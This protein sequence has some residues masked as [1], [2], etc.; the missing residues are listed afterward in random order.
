MIVVWILSRWGE[1]ELEEL[2]GV[3]PS[4][5]DVRESFC[6]RAVRA[7]GQMNLVGIDMHEPVRLERGGELLL[8]LQLALQTEHPVPRER[9]DPAQASAAVALGNRNRA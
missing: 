1:G 7:R 8:A 2:Y 5:L 9:L 4:R 3:V 6:Q